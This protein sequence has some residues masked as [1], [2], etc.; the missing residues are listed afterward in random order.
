M[1]NQDIFEK[2]MLELMEKFSKA[3]KVEDTKG[4]AEAFSRAITLNQI[5]NYYNNLNSNYKEEENIKTK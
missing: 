1:T 3:S 4:M 2:Q 5:M